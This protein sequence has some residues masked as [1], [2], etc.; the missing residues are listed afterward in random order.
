M[1]IR[2]SFYILN[3]N[4]FAPQ[5][6]PIRLFIQMIKNNCISLRDRN[7]GVAH[8]RIRVDAFNALLTC[9]VIFSIKRLLG[10]QLIKSK[11]SPV[12]QYS[13]TQIHSVEIIPES[14]VL[15]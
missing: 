10:I 11:R 5:P 12:G 13:T 8:K 2:D 1:C 4:E 9:A 14:S 3:I 7:K 6:Y 15:K